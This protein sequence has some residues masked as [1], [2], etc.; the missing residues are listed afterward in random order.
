VLA[1]LVG[2]SSRS[3]AVLLC[4]ALR[5]DNKDPHPARSC[6]ACLCFVLLPDAATT[7]SD[8]TGSLDCFDIVARRHRRRGAAASATTPEANYRYDRASSFVDHMSVLHGGLDCGRKP[9]EPQRHVCRWLCPL[10]FEWDFRRWTFIRWP[11]DSRK[12]GPGLTASTAR[13]RI[14]SLSFSLLQSFSPNAPRETT[15]RSCSSRSAQASSSRSILSAA[16]QT[17][18][19]AAG[20]GTTRM[21]RERDHRSNQYCM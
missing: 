18:R 2:F 10:G 15:G 4:G 12:G 1:G 19:P 21:R 5:S 9:E 6:A 14:G 17:T 13:T 16:T 8:P 11:S 20:V 3:A 7:D